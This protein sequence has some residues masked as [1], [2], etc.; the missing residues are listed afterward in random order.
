MVVATPMSLGRGQAGLILGLC[1]VVG[2]I[3][4]VL[5][6][7]SLGDVSSQESDQHL[8]GIVTT[9]NANA[10]DGAAGGN[11]SAP[12]VSAQ[13]ECCLRRLLQ[14][15]TAAHCVSNGK[16]PLPR[17]TDDAFASPIIAA[18]TSPCVCA[19]LAHQC[20]LAS[21]HET[22]FAG[23]GASAGSHL[24]FS[25]YCTSFQCHL[26]RCRIYPDSK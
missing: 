6:P 9:V 25:Q 21:C 14:Y 12:H 5:K 4:G 19:F 23:E 3:L 7:D 22:S 20:A 15:I 10:P 17:V 26:L 16:L 18:G 13:N 2:I 11:V 1:L 8:R 24:M